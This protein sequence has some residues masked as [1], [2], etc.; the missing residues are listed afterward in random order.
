MNTID[1]MQNEKDF[2][3]LCK[4]FE[5]NQ[6]F[7]QIFGKSDNALLEYEVL[8][9]NVCLYLKDCYKFLLLVCLFD[10]I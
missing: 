7:E 9:S 4:K 8:S 6:D 1:D 10:Q 5:Y 2:F 3:Y